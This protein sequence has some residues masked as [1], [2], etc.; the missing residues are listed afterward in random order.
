MVISKYVLAVALSAAMGIS[1]IMNEGAEPL[2]DNELVVP[3][4]DLTDVAPV[5]AVL[6]TPDT[7]APRDTS[8]SPKAALLP[9]RRIQSPAG[10][11]GKTDLPHKSG[12][13]ASVHAR[14]QCNWNVQQLKTVTT[15]YRERWY[16]YEAFASGSSTTFNKNTSYDAHPH[17]TCSGTGKYT[18]WGFSN[19]YTLE[20]GKQF[21]T[22]TANGGNNRVSRFTC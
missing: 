22:R 18:Y 9:T 21:Y 10:C 6:E 1:G 2:N 7:S 15:L 12:R 20:G 11:T 17:W 5:E 19:H 4:S 13:M 8:V 14:I 3:V 16:G